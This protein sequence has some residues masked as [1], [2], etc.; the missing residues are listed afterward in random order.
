MRNLTNKFATAVTVARHILSK[1][2]GAG[3][4]ISCVLALSLTGCGTNYQDAVEQTGPAANGYFTSIKEWSDGI[5]T[6]EIV[7]A[8]DTKVKYLI[9]QNT[10]GHQCAYGITPLY[11]ADGTLQVYE[12]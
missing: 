7:Y 8:N 9:T 12:G 2:K 6:Y 1:A 4:I 11:N 3:I 10:G 5:F